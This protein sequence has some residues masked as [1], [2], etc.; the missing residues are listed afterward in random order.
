MYRTGSDT[1]E[2]YRSALESGDPALFLSSLRLVSYSKEPEDPAYWMDVAACQIGMSRAMRGDP[3]SAIEAASLIDGAVF[4]FSKAMVLSDRSDGILAYA[5]FADAIGRLFDAVA[6]KADAIADAGASVA[7]FNDTASCFL[8]AAR[9]AYATGM[10]ADSLTLSSL[11]CLNGLQAAVRAWM[12]GKTASASILTEEHTGTARL[13]LPHLRGVFDNTVPADDNT[14]RADNGDGAPWLHAAHSRR[15][16]HSRDI[17]AIMAIVGSA[18]SCKAVPVLPA[19]R[20][21]LLAS[22]PQPSQPS[23][24]V[25]SGLSD[26]VSAEAARNAGNFESAVALYRGC[27]A[28]LKRAYAKER[29]IVGGT[30]AWAMDRLATALSP[31][32]DARDIAMLESEMRQLRG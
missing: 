21:I 9:T 19:G 6:W 4:S 2:T 5:V 14:I 11:S 7:C 22:A 20:G 3:R 29:D 10:A 1:E 16:W 13:L 12:A 23:S 24:D 17:S 15:E 18:E 31:M 30:L 25:I 32:N 26:L 8:A 28:P 27:I